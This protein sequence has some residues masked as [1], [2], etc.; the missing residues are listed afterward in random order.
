MIILLFSVQSGT[1]H[2]LFAM[3]KPHEVASLNCPGIKLQR[4][5]YFFYLSCDFN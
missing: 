4:E 1:D 2:P 3:G 5:I